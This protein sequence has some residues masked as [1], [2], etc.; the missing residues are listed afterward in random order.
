MSEA[1]GGGCNLCNP[2]LRAALALNEPVSFTV[3]KKHCT[4]CGSPLRQQAM[5]QMLDRRGGALLA[6]LGLKGTARAIMAAP[7][8]HE[9]DLLRPL[10]ASMQP[11]SLHGSYGDHHVTCDTRDMSQFPAAGFDLFEASLVFDYVPE[12]ETAIASVVRVLA[13][14]AAIFVYINDSRLL[15][16]NEEPRV[17]TK[18]SRND[19]LPGYYP[20]D[21]VR[22]Q[23]KL[24]R[25]WF[26]AA[27]RRHGFEIEEFVWQHPFTDEPLTWWVGWRR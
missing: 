25:R 1:S 27:W 26:A 18:R 11:F 16:G 8:R 21:Y 4:V 10:V 23:I 24:G 7:G 5:G 22:E 15:P 19:G 2:A 20:E 17:T 3:D 6:E 14:P 12:V 9:R 13:R